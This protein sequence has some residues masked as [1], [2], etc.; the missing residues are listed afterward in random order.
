M[1]E[2]DALDFIVYS[3]FGDIKKN[4]EDA[5]IGRAYVDMASHTLTGIKDYN[6]KWDCRYRASRIIKESLYTLSDGT[7]FDDWHDTLCKELR[8]IY[9]GRLSYGQA[10]KWV[11]MTIKY[12]YVLKKLGAVDEGIFPYISEKHVSE[13][14]PPI[15]SYILRGVIKDNT[16]WSNIDTVEE[17]KE[18]KDRLKKEDFDFKSELK[19][20]P[21][22]AEEQRQYDKK[23]YAA[24]L[25]KHDSRQGE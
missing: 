17:Y 11:N 8:D 1:N 3:F 22:I 7:N 23:S 4:P 13:F 15:D 20:W 12:A 2:K 16:A 5:I 19:K 10:Q 6:E 18:L 9:S 24:F 25:K 14:H 21:Q